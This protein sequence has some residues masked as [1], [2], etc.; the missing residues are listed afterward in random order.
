M[1]DRLKPSTGLRHGGASA[2]AL[3]E[4][5]EKF[6]D[7]DFAIRGDLASLKSVARYR[8]TAS[9]VK[10]LQLLTPRQ[11]A[12]ARDVPKIVLRSVRKILAA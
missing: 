2:D 10:Q 8:R 6:T 4:G 11:P 3:L 9:D 7:L 1:E 5:D 12:E